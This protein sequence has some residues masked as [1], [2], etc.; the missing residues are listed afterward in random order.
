M[1]D[2]TDVFIIGA[3]MSYLDQ[4]E[5][6]EAVYR[7]TGAVRDAIQ[8]MKDHH[9]NWVRL[10]LWHTP[11]ENY[12]NLEKTLAMAKRVKANGLKLLLNFHYSDTWADPS[13]QTKPAAWSGLSFEQLKVSLYTYTKQVVTELREQNTLPDMIQVGNEI[14][15][16][17]LWD[18][19][20]V[21]ETFDNPAQ[22]N[23]FGQLLKS[24]IQGVKDAL[25]GNET[26][27]IMIHAHSGADNAISRWF[28][29]HIVAEG[30]D[31]DVIGLSYYPFWQQWGNNLT[32]LE[33]NLNDL[34]VRYGKD[35]VIAETASPWSLENFDGFPNIVNDPLQVHPGYPASVEGQQ[36][37]LEKLITILKEI[38][39]QR[40]KG[41]FYY[42]PE[43]ITSPLMDSC[44]ENVSLFDNYGELLPSVDAFIP[45][46]LK[47]ITIQ[48]NMAAIPEMLESDTIVQVRGELNHSSPVVLPDGN[49]LSWGADTTLELYNDG[50]DLY[51]GNFYLP[52]KSDFRFKLFSPNGGGWED[53]NISGDEYGNTVIIVND[54]KTLPLHFFTETGQK[55]P[56]DLS[57]WPQKVA[58]WLRVYMYTSNGVSQGYQLR[59]QVITIGVRGDNLNGAGP[60]EW[61]SSH[62]LLKRE[63]TNPNESAYHLFSGV[64]YYPKTL[65]GKNQKYK[66]IV[67]PSGWEGGNLTGDREFIIPSHDQSIHW[68]YFGDTNPIVQ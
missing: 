42:S 53:G 38:P 16:G 5:D 40:G 48:T 35:I 32:N 58:V 67:E 25:A 50:T 55:K 28:Y 64:V 54:N 9:M 26:I 43:Y 10:R 56:Y 18:D 65:A 8:I 21:N 46:G 20:R 51:I 31:F 61:E 59:S 60:L 49:I 39:N 22:W 29:D 66:F 68:V 27:P 11:L 14:T 34:S 19:G 1:N 62:V 13:N 24:A 12:N 52:K 36:Q 57:L 4:E 7:D 15:N 41:F 37:F 45:E 33:L 44:W 17:M 2:T 6:C 63:S 47:R 30:V 23:H 3:D